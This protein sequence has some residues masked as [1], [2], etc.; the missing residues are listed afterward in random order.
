MDPC[1]HRIPLAKLIEADIPVSVSRHVDRTAEVEG[2]KRK[3]LR[4][5][6]VVQPM[7][8]GGLDHEPDSE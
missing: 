3:Y 8:E 7:P 6:L 2:F 4:R 1:P 5:G